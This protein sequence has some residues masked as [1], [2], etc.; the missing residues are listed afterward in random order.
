MDIPHDQQPQPWSVGAVEYQESFAGFTELYADEMLDLL[1]VTTGTE[2]VDVA[3]GTGAAS[4]SAVRRGARVT[5]VDF[6]PGMVEVA[7]ARLAEHDAGAVALVMDGQHLELPDDS[8]DAG[9]SMFGLMFFPDLDAGFRELARV[10]RVGG[11]VGTAT[12]DLSAFPMHRLI[13]TSLA[14]VV[15]EFAAGD[16]PVPTWAPLGTVAG[17]RSRLIAAGLDDVDVRP[18]E[19]RWRFRDAA[20]F[21]RDMPGWSPPVQ[22]LFDALPPA[23]AE[24]AA[25]AFQDVV[26]DGGRFARRT[27]YPH[28]GPARNRHR[29][30]VTGLPARRSWL[31]RGRPSPGCR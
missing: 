18:V 29:R 20:L 25:L 23:A 8:F 13:A 21:F 16:A 14:R 6:A 19:R 24:A 31:R 12:W 15:P 22:S 26:T 3:A 7:A 28:D 11:R 4:V 5:A 1:G 17:L 10:V 9:V 2:L 27:R 30:R